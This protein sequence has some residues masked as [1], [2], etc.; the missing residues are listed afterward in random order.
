M[1]NLERDA[2]A[3]DRLSAMGWRV[4]VIWEC[5]TKSE[6]SLDAVFQRYGL[7]ALSEELSK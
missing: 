1:A 2:Q 7:V 5:E 3:Y 6:L 4:M